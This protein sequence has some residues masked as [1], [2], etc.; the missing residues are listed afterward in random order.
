[1]T[2]WMVR[3]GKYGETEKLAIEEKVAIIGWDDVPDL[4]NF[5]TRQEL[6]LALDNIYPDAKGATRSTWE[7]QL[8][9]FAQVMTKGDTIAMP[10]KG[11]SAILLGRIAGPYAYRKINGV[12]YHTRPVDWGREAP[13]SVFAQ[14]LL[15]SLGSI[16]TVCRVQRNEAERRVAEIV[17]GKEDP[18]LRGKSPTNNG[19]AKS[20]GSALKDDVALAGDETSVVD[21][22][23]IAADAIRLKIGSVFKGHRLSSLIGAILETQG[24]QVDVSPPGADGG[25]DIVAGKGPLGFD[26]PRIAVQVKSQESAVDVSVLRELQGVM[27]QFSADQGLL[28]AWGGVTKALEREAK[29]LFFGIRIWNDNDI[30]KAVQQA[31]DLLPEEIQADLP[32]KRIWILAD[33]E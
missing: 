14:D 29:R 12:D 30:I 31:Y 19:L 18:L 10:L 24:Y 20:Y 11:R 13:R 3:S 25:V 8:W 21:L 4:Q 15:F 5:K 1:M 22:A 2:L 16:L 27:S 17:A 32:M 6:R 28:V 33:Q 23:Q 7:S 26:R 9:P